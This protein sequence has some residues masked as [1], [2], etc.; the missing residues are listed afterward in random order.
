MT[1]QCNKWVCGK[2]SL[3]F[4]VRI[5]PGRWMV[6]VASLLLNRKRKETL[7]HVSDRERS[8]SSHH[9]WIQK[10]Y[11]KAYQTF[12]RLM[13]SLSSWLR[14]SLPGPMGWTTERQTIIAVSCRL[15][16]FHPDSQSPPAIWSPMEISTIIY[17]M[18]VWSCGRKKDTWSAC[19][20]RGLYTMT[21]CLDT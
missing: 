14:L 9:L 13:F 16:P 7:C 4:W 20:K 5:S 1:E 6:A 18:G 12:S 15:F 19:C 3:S 17:R 10:R 11:K 2:L 21:R 8:P